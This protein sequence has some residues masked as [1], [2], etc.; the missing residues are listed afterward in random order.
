VFAIGVPNRI[1]HKLQHLKIYQFGTFTEWSKIYRL[2]KKIA[3]VC[4][5]VGRLLIRD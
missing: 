1:M 3:R 4:Q 2:D 5:G